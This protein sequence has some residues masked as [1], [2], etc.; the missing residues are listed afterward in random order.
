MSALRKPLLDKASERVRG[1]LRSA[2]SLLRWIALVA[3]ILAVATTL[4]V[5]TSQACPGTENAAPL[6]T[7]SLRPIGTKHS[8]VASSVL[9]FTIKDTSCCGGG[10]GYCHGVICVGSC[11]SACLAVLIVA[12]WTQDFAPHV[13]SPP[14]QICLPLA[15]SDTQFRPPRLFL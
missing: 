15:E 7:P 6:V 9:K 11:C 13:D 14:P 10:S 4:T 2:G 12:A 3:A 5:D 8:S 1:V